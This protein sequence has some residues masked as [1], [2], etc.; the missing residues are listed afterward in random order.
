VNKRVLVALA[1]VDFKKRFL[2][3][4]FGILWA[5]IQPIITILVF[6][7]VFQV[8][9]K[10]QPNENMP[11]I[12]WLIPGII[13]WFFFS[14]T[15]LAGT[16][17]IVEYNFLV[18]KIVFPV[19]Y[20]SLIKLLSTLQIHLFFIALTIILFAWDGYMPSWYN[21]QIFY[22]LFG[23][24]LLILG[25]SWLCSA[26]MVF[27][28]DLSQVVQIILQ[29]GFWLTPIFWSFNAMSVKYKFLIKLNP[30][31]YIVQGY[32]NSLIDKVWFWQH[33]KLSLYFWLFTLSILWMGY[34]VFNKLKPHFADAI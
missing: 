26:I 18:K 6:W 27:I 23:L 11:F 20:L 12:L 21:L 13:P 14:D 22:Y 30:I 4:H 10:T 28:R 24:S 2:E 5:F 1:K 19:Q 17:S 29:F 15:L 16:N 34:Q 25:L 3:T 33:P 32:R 7:F 8:G 31:F 9:F